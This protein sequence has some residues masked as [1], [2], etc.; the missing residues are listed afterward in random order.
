MS[1]RIS[2]AD[3]HHGHGVTYAGLTLHAPATWHT[4]A[5]TG[6]SALMWCAPQTYFCFYYNS[7]EI[8]PQH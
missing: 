6:M 1:R 5:G 3:A 2:I 4:V 7:V 8:M